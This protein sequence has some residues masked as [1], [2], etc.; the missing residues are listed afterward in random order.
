MVVRRERVNFN[1]PSLFLMASH[2]HGCRVLEKK[3]ACRAYG[4][5]RTNVG[6]VRFAQDRDAQ[7]IA[8]H[9]DPVSRLGIDHACPCSVI[10]SETKGT[11]RVMC[12][13]A[14]WASSWNLAGNKLDH[15]S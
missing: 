15:D 1:Y 7:L 11:N 8:V 6:W 5:G 2:D 13:S 10:V 12:V 9:R 14:K 3:R 4:M